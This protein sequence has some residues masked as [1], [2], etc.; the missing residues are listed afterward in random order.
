MLKIGHRGIAG[1]EPENTLR[2]FKKAIELG[3][4]AIEFDIHQVEEQLVII[5]DSSVDRTTNGTG[6]VAPWPARYFWV[7]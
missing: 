5:H 2:G 7:T 1:L 4:R 3:F 6:K